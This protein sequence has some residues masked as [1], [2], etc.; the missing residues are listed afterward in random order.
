[1]PRL[2]RFT[3]ALLVIGLVPS[4]PAQGVIASPTDDVVVAT[5]TTQPVSGSAEGR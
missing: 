4:T 3:P 2:L 5:S 1:M